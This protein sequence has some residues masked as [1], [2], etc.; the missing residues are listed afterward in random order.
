MKSLPDLPS[1]AESLFNKY[2]A[3]ARQHWIYIAAGAFL[4]LL[5]AMVFFFKNLMG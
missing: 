2:D 3:L 1:L 4:V 5:V